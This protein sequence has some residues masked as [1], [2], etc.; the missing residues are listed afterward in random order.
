M[1]EREDEGR[2]GDPGLLSDPQHVHLTYDPCVS[3]SEM[4]V[5]RTVLMCTC[6]LA[7]NDGDPNH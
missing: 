5:I 2:E 4:V 6:S 3:P 7:D 1:G